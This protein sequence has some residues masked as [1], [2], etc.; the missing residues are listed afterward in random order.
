MLPGNPAVSLVQNYL[1]TQQGVIEVARPTPE[2]LL[3]TVG[4]RVQAT[5][6]G[7][8]QSGRFAVLI[9]DQLLDLNL[10]RN[11]QP[12]EQLEL[13]VLSKEP[14]L[15]FSLSSSQQAAAQEQQALARGFQPG[16]ALSP[17]GKLLGELLARPPG[18]AQ[19]ATLQQ[20]QPLFEGEPQ[21]A[22]LAGQLASRL[23]ESGLFYE[24]HQA[25][26]VSG[27]RSL[28]TLLREPQARLASG[29][30]TQVAQEAARPNATSEAATKNASLDVR[31]VMAGMTP[32]E[33][34]KSPDQAVRQLVRQQLELLENHPLVWQ[35]QAWPDQPL[36]WK[37]E[38]EN[39]RDPQAPESEA[40]RVWQTRLDMALPRLGQVGVVASLRD[41]QFSLCFEAQAPETVQALQRNQSTLASRFEAAGLKLVSTQ[42]HHHVDEAGA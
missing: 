14:K 20:M 35:G 39:E 29:E 7:Q 12:G 17:A 9:K 32:D 8:M 21:P 25:E 26:W 31:M 38:L 11:T 28:Q 27:E 36:R 18:Q 41:G 37:L 15:T 24:S 33:Q 23:A 4:E 5:V 42:V 10:P 19:G 34:A 30:L 3:L 16:A 22:Q 40:T 1:R 2:Q 13:T 6:T